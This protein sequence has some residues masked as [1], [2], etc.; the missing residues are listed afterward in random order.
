MPEP[1]KAAPAAIGVSIGLGVL[2]LLFYA[3]T[4]AT[5][6]DLAGSDAA[7][8]GYA[9]A[10]AAI[11]IIIV[12]SLLAVIAIIAGV[13]GAIAWPAALVA[14]IL[15]PASG[16]VSFE[17]LELLSRPRLPPFLWPLIIPALAPLLIM[18]F[19]IWA[20]FP[21][22]RA[23][24][25][26]SV[27]AGVIWG[28]TLLL[29]VAIVPF[30]K[31]REHADDLVAD[32]QAKYD[33]DL[34]KLPPDAPLWDWAPF[35]DTRNSTKQSELLA[36]I[37]TL[38]R[39]Q[40]DAELMLERGDFPLRYLGS[41]DLTPTASICDKARALLRRQVE[42][43]MLKSRN[44]KRYA[45]I[46]EPVSNALTA[47]KWLVGYECSCDAESLAW[48]TM[49]KTYDKPNYDVYELAE[50]RDP[51][52]F[53]RIVRRYPERFSML[54]PRAHLK[55]WLSFADKKEFHDQ[56]LAGARKLDHRT[57]DA[58][59]MLNDKYDIAAPWQVLKYMPVL[60]L[61]MTPR[62]CGA[63]LTQVHGDFAKVLQPKPDDPRR[64]S[65]LLDRLGAYEPLTALVWLAGHGCD[66]EG[67]LS[68]AEAVIRT[69][70]DLPARA[71]M[72]ATLAQLHRKN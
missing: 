7:G 59:E 28:A 3:L 22:L 23:R 10:Y 5:L 71:A 72:L 35:L 24:I 57:A 17:V 34:A 19:S 26:E 8:N 60:D 13:K 32:A 18:S 65:E 62:L 46:A 2:A 25:P 21:S 50:L 33:A 1:A 30:D 20:L 63:A 47:M 38:D 48:E 27:A 54:T 14:A 70:Q 69:Y 51:K 15:I 66:A 11:E 40:S 6:S 9:Q 61:E 45:E 64:Y 56:A 68:E 53:G 55:A 49:A 4:L 31:M 41:L 44:S 39:R 12:W 16:F 29:C 36:H 43:L 37:R 67:E 42:P 58:V 52:N